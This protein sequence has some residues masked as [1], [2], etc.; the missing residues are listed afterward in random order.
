MPFVLT[1]R[2]R[3][4]LAALLAALCLAGGALFTLRAMLPDTFYLAGGGELRIASL[5]FLS[6]RQP[7]GEAA[8]AGG[9][10]ADKSQNVT[11]TLFDVIPVKTVRTVAAERRTVNAGGTPFG[12]KM[13]SNGALVVAFSDVYT[14]HG[15]E[16]PAKE[17]G[18]KLGDLITSIEGRAVR[19]NNDLTAAITAAAGGVLQ[20]EYLRDGQSHT[21]TLTPAA[22]RDTGAWRAGVW[23]RDSSAGIGTLTFTDPAHGTFAGLGHAISDS[24]TGARIALLTGEIV[25]VTITGCVR[26]AAGAP[27]ELRGE[28]AGEAVLGTVLANDAT[29]VYGTLRGSVPGTACEVAEQQEVALGP[30]QILATVDGGEAQLYD[31]VIERV[32]MTAA[33][34]NR[35]LLVRVTDPELLQKTGGIVQGM[36]GSPILQNGRLVGA[37]THVLVNDPAHGYGIFARTML[38]RADAIAG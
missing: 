2:R 35:N 32:N 14:A 28:F 18:L 21:C 11:L 30:A 3:R 12:V 7:Q 15:S 4:L 20:V 10:P 8:E 34:P 19:S 9:I 25:P 29:G 1:P 36:S 37:V 23:V 16:N 17:A 26:G 38:N 33:D 13:F 5:P 22:D 27:G 31:A 24:D 6:A